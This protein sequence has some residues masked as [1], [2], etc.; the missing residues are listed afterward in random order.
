MPEKNTRYFLK[1]KETKA[2]L[3][4]ASR[5]LKADFKQI[6]VGNPGIEVIR[7]E[8]AQIFFANG[9][10]L[11]IEAD[12][13]LYPSLVSNELLA[14]MPK[15]IVDMGA[16]PYVCKGADVMAPGIRR[17]E[18]DFGKGDLVV[19]IDEK[20][21]KAVAIGEALFDR[22]E[23]VKVNRGIVVKNVHFVSD[24]TWNRIKELQAKT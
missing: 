4:R 5:R 22:E 11:L 16:V 20:Y 24:K 18:R 12:G 6:L 21:G 13:N 17:Y 3:D 2:L 15:V 1:D 14:I 8:V 7:T 23:A 10:P 9:K 19:I